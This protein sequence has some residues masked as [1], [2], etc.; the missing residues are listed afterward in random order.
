MF[1]YIGSAKLF[2][3]VQGLILVWGRK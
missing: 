1:A 2:E 3:Q